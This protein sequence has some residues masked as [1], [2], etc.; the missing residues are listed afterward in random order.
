M[1]EPDHC[2]DAGPR[3]CCATC[4]DICAGCFPPFASEHCNRIFQSPSW[5]DKF[6]MHDAFSV[7]KKTNQHWLTLLRTCA[8]FGHGEVGVFLWDEC[9]F[10]SGSYPNTQDSSPVMMLE[11]KVVLFSACSLRW[12][13]TAMQ[14]SFWITAYQPWHRFCCIVQLVGLIRQNSLAHSIWHLTVLQTSW[15]IHLWSSG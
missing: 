2:H 11:M 15:I 4:L 9:C 1:R 12:V 3:R 5:W 6:L 13:Q 8:F 7:K 10:I 14:Y